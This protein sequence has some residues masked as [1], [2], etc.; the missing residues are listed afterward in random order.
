MCRG[1]DGRIRNVD[2]VMLTLQ[3]GT[4]M[5]ELPD[6]AAIRDVLARDR[7]PASQSC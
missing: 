3:M 6:L 1:V 7:N 2:M 4:L 5:E